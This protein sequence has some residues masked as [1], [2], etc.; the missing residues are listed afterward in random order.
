[1]PPG[2]G[3]HE[4]E[5]EDGNKGSDTKRRVWCPHR[6]ALTMMM[7][8]Y[9]LGMSENVVIGPRTPM[10]C[11]GLSEWMSLCGAS[12]SVSVY[13]RTRHRHGSHTAVELDPDPPPHLPALDA[14]H[15]EPHLPVLLHVV[16]GGVGPLD[17]QIRVLDHHMLDHHLAIIFPHRRSVE[18]HRVGSEQTNRSGRDGNDELLVRGTEGGGG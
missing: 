15:H 3:E 17:L 5:D 14:L 8:S 16:D 13:L 6:A 11:P 1:M 18:A 10:S 12:V 9:A 4:H 7:L 2:E